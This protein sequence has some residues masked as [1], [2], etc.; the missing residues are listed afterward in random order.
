[1]RSRYSAFA[2]S[3][4]DYLSLTWH[5]E[6]RPADLTLDSGERWVGLEVLDAG[7]EGDV[8][9]VHFKA[10][11]RDG[12]G[13]AVLEEESRFVREAGRWYYRDGDT[14]VSALTPGRN[15]TCLCGSGRKFK[16]CC[17]A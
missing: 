16:K 2:L 6:T 14:R 9:W 15:D 12:K 4:I 8:G 7:S 1:M 11:S 10:T 13:F 17:G 5:P 3:N